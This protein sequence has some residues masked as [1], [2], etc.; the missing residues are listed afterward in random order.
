MKRNV[1]VVGAGPVGLYLTVALA[2]R[3]HRV[4]VVDRDP[5]PPGD[6]DWERRGVMQFHHPH[7]IRDQAV[8]ALDAEMPDVH[9]ALLA[10]GAA[11]AVLPGGIRAGV[12]CRRPTLERA[13]RSAAAAEPGVTVLTGH[14]RDVIRDRGRAAGIKVDGRTLAADLVLHAGGRGGTLGADLR[15]AAEDQDCGIA[16]VSRHHALLPGAEPGP[17]TNAF[18]ILEQ[19]DGYAVATFLQDARTFS[20][21]ILRESGDQELAGLR[22]VASYEA[23]CAAIPGLAA[24]TD[25]ERSRPITAPRAGGNVRNAYRGQG[26]LAGLVHVGDA[27]CITN[28]IAGRGIATSLMQAQNLVAALDAHDDPHDV[29]DAFDA[30]CTRAIRPWFDDHVRSDPDRLARYRGADVDL[31]RPLTSGWIVETMAASAE[32]RPLI[33]QYL[34]MRVLPGELAAIEPAARAVYRGGWRPPRPAGPDRIALVKAIS[35]GGAYV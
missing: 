33:L 16:Y 6:D 5:G 13:L 28:P 10:L 30:Y 19:H 3:G 11:D 4:T 1:A 25:P 20:T 34:Q 18:G 14:V 22:D 29:R 27:V 35:G 9:D 32:L 7:A 23:A 12:H 8:E 21:L 31:D 2:R 26:A 15:P 24:W 17:M